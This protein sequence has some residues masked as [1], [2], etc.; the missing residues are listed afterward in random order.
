MSKWY[1]YSNRIQKEI[2][3]MM[4]QSHRQLYFSGGGIIN[5]NVDTFGSV[6]YFTPDLQSSNDK[7]FLGG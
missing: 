1:K 3:F 4:T 5:I 2:L 6:R 7:L